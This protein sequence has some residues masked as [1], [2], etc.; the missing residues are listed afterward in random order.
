MNRAEKIKALYKKKG[1][2]FKLGFIF[3]NWLW[4]DKEKDCWNVTIAS[5]PDYHNSL[6]GPAYSADFNKKTGER[7]STTGFTGVYETAVT[8]WPIRNEKKAVR[9]FSYV[10]EEVDSAYNK[11]IA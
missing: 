8:M 6:W 1:K 11:F 2:T 3:G 10:A 4:I 9:I 7:L 5:G